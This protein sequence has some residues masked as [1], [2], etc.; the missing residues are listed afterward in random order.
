MREWALEFDRKGV[1]EIEIA[2]ELLSLL[3]PLGEPFDYVGPGKAGS[4]GR[5]FSSVRLHAVSGKKIAM[6]LAAWPWIWRARPT[7][8]AN[9]SKQES[10]CNG[11]GY[12][13]FNG[14]YDNEGKRL[15]A[16]FQ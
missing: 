7:G 13:W 9:T 3:D 8:S 12:G 4:F 14:Y 5:I 1:K 11:E 10:L 16:D 6:G 2:A 15:K